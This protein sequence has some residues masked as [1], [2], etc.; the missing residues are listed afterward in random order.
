MKTNYVHDYETLKNCFIGVFEDV[1]S[2]NKKY[3]CVMNPEM[4]SLI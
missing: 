4:I 1:K 3:L 2:E